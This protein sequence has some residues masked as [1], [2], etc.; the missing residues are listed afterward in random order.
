MVRRVQPCVWL[1]ALMFLTTAA[2]LPAA[3]VTVEEN[4]VYGKG[5]GKDLQLDLARP[6]E[7]NGA[8][9]AIVYIHGGGWR[10]GNRKAYRKDIAEAAKRGY[11]A[12]TVSYRLVDPDDAGKA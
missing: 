3:D 9:P 6:N 8:R 7:L 5:G 4:I 12:V 10:G 2:A 11:V 1:A